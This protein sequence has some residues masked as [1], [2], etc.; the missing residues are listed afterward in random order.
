MPAI[1]DAAVQLLATGMPVLFLDIIRGRVVLVSM[2]HV[3]SSASLGGG[4]SGRGG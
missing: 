2:T 4:L 1:G 3:V